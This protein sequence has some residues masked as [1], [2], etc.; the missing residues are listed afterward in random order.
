MKIVTKTLEGIADIQFF[1]IIGLIIF[2]I[3]FVVLLYYVAQLSK[4]QID[5][6]SRLP[7]DDAQD[8][9]FENDESTFSK[10]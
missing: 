3:M 1:P 2:F 9:H 6:F 5:E 10:K 7:L 4:N 8:I